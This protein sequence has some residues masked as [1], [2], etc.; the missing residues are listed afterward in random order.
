MTDAADLVR[1]LYDELGS[2]PAVA[3]ALGRSASLWWQIGYGRRRATRAQANA[4]LRY[5][6]KP[7]L[8]TPPAE[9]VAA[10]GVQYVVPLD[11]NPDVALLAR[12]EGEA[13][14]RVRMMGNGQPIGNGGPAPEATFTSCKTPPVKRKRRSTCILSLSQIGPVEPEKLGRGKSGEPGAIAAA[15]ARAAAALEGRSVSE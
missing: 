3:V 15:A 8:P 1:Q 12:T 13:I 9:V 6:G 4:V 10:S 14:A 7:E 2:W 5:Y 11:D